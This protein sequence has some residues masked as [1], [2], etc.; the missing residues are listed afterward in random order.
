MT[1]KTERIVYV[2]C[3]I[4]I[5]HT[6]AA[7]AVTVAVFVIIGRTQTNVVAKTAEGL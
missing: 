3:G 7:G 4:P 5:H 1:K 6:D 2:T